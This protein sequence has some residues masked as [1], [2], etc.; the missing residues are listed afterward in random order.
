VQSSEVEWIVVPKH[1]HTTARADDEYEAAVV[2]HCSPNGEEI[3]YGEE[4][5]RNEAD[6]LHADDE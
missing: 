5:N 3:E 6:G 4:D 2:E 1:H